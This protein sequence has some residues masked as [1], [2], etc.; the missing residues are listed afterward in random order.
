VKSSLS[1][2]TQ[3]AV[4]ITMWSFVAIW[5]VGCGVSA[6]TFAQSFG[7]HDPDAFLG[8]MFGGAVLFILVDA[9]FGYDDPDTWA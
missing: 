7:E 1:T 2:R 3:K 9:V 4:G 8:I 5:L 6:F